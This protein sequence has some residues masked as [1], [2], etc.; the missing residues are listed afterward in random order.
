M[1]E[2]IFDM[3]RIAALVRER[4]GEAYVEQTGGGCATIFASLGCDERGFPLADANGHYGAA[5]GPG[6]FEGEGWTLPRGGS[7]EFLVGP[8]DD[9]DAT[10]YNATAEDTEETLA[11]RICQVLRQAVLA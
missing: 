5:A 1:S 8:D 3:D 7:S 11:E 2:R 6:W 10:P 4:G 9:G